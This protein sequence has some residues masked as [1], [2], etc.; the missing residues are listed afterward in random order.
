MI[1]PLLATTA[2]RLTQCAQDLGGLDIL[3]VGCGHLHQGAVM[4]APAMFQLL[5]FAVGGVAIE[6]APRT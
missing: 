1:S 4:S 6:L 5:I 2:D 3:E